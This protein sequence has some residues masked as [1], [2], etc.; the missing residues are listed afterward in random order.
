MSTSKILQRPSIL[1]ITGSTI[2]IAH[3]DLSS[4]PLTYVNVPFTAGGTALYVYDNAR[5][6]DNDY[7]LL[8]D[9]GDKQAEEVDIN[10]A[11]T[12][13]QTL[14]ITN[15]TK[16]SHE[17]DT[18]V[19]KILERGIKIYGAATDGGA[20]TLITSIDAIT[21]PI[22][23]ATMID[24]TAPF[25]EYTLIS[26]DTAYAYYFVKFTDGTTDSSASDYVA[27][28]GEDGGALDNL[29]QSALDLTNTELN[30]HGITR[31][32]LIRQADRCQDYIK[33][34]AYQLPSGRTVTKNWSFELT[35]GTLTSVENENSYA[36]SGLSTTI[37]KNNSPDAILNVRIGSNEPLER[38][39]IQDM[40]EELATYPNTTLASDATAGDT[41][42]TLT[43]SYDFDESG[44]VY[45]VGQTEAVTYTANAEATGVLSGVPASGSGAITSTT[46]LA[47]TSVWQGLQP[48]LPTKYAIYEGNIILN[49]PIDE[50]YAGQ[51]IKIDYFKEL[52]RIEDSSD[53]TQ[54]PFYN[55]FEYWL[56][57][58]IETRKQRHDVAA[59]YMKQFEE[60]LRNNAKAD[61][62]PNIN[63]SNRYTFQDPTTYF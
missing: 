13:G 12:R 14:T 22:A 16:F 31:E 49:R 53:V 35:S 17:I 54:I 38:V 10:G 57:A 5:L 48:D 15:S 21:T 19:R 2:K 59:N 8:G 52:T 44:S 34:Y 18:P 60:L 51:K 23:D 55:I 43:D 25:T 36:L 62:V 39:N 58:K 50:D 9:I 46:A 11:V 1:G 32:F 37:K 45:I 33:T 29:I 61:R 7:L 28:T 24:W 20:G 41:T 56:A 4:Y 30:S 6:A 40:R 26:T 47:A 42:L 63:F 3:P 27:A